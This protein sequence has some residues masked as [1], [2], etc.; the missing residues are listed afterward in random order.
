MKPPWTVLHIFY[1]YPPVLSG[2]AK[3]SHEIV[4]HTSAFAK[5]IIVTPPMDRAK[6]PVPSKANQN[7]GEIVYR[8]KK[9]PL[10]PIKHIGHRLAARLLL[11]WKLRE[12]FRHHPI[13]LVHAHMPYLQALPALQY[14][15]RHAVPSLYEVR[16][17]WEDSAVAE[18]KISAQSKKYRRRRS[19]EDCAMRSADRV[20]VLS[21]ALRREVIGRGIPDEKVTLVSNGVDCEAFRPQPRSQR[22]IERFGLQ[23]KCVLGYLGT[24]RKLEGIQT[25]FPVLAKL[26]QQKEKLVFLIVGFGEYE[27]QLRQCVRELQLEKAVIFAGAVPPQEAG[28]YY[29]AMDLVLFPRLRLRVTELVTPLK[30]LEAMAME[31][32]VLGSRVGG[33]EEYLIEGE[34]ASLFEPGDEKEMA[35]KILLFARNPEARLRLGEKA[36][37]WVEQNKDWK[38]L[39]QKYFNLYQELLQPSS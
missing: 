36:R 39:A 17:V 19:N 1:H 20:V 23:G 30:P 12:I 37:R 5:S 16:G 34:N 10:P 24:L 6:A 2:Y 9:L 14:A 38:V 15:R 29:S 31:K 35:E 33:L 11:E 25:V 22:L 3:R 32:C 28:E 27:P 8:L 7:H 18:D 21:E 13:D 4:K 26:I